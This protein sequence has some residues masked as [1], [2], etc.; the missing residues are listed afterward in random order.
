M[1]GVL[2]AFLVLGQF[3]Y[4]PGGSGILPSAFTKCQAA[5]RTCYSAQLARLAFQKAQEACTG[6]GGGLSTAN[7]ATEVSTILTLLG[8]LGNTSDTHFFWLGL[9]RKA[10]QCTR[11]DLPLRGFSWALAGDSMEMVRNESGLG[12]LRE[13]SKSCTVERC[14][15]LQVMPGG[16]RLE[17]WGLRDHICTKASAG[18]VCKYIYDGGCSALKPSSSLGYL[19]PHSHLQSA[20]I[21]FSPPGTELT[22]RCPRGREARFTC[23]L[24]TDGYHWERE[25]EEWLCSCPSGY[26]SPKEAACMELDTCQD[27]QG[28]FFCLC[29]LGSRLGTNAKACLQAV[30][31]GGAASTSQPGL[32][33]AVPS[34]SSVEERFPTEVNGS[35][36]EEA[37]RPLSDSSNYIFILITVAVVMLVILVMA[38]LQVFQF[39]FR[40]CSPSSSASKEPA[41]KDGA[42]VG[43]EKG[44]T[45]AS[46]TRTNSEHSLGPSKAESLEASP[47]EAS[48]E[49]EEP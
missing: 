12:W 39:C 9:V 3:F 44:D 4:S 49:M 19:L 21:E 38:A 30:Q 47:E 34:N 41:G 7:S 26:W 48:P 37:P 33:S 22:L 13:P 35:M 45:E 25:T 2:L 42:T 28:A 16:P 18:Y 10:Q 36:A 31:N 23:R 46:A 24:S 8:N 43:A 15:G 1:K 14:A 29:A 11:E 6:Q 27:P 17:P 5:S 20:A 40:R 32:L